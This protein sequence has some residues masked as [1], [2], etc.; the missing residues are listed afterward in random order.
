MT[1]LQTFVGKKSFHWLHASELRFP[2]FSTLVKTG[3]DGLSAVA[4]ERADF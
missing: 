2:I 4:S 3:K 1:D